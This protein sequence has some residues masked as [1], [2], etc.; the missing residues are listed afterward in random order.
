[1]VPVGAWKKKPRPQGLL[2]FQY[3]G[4]MREDPFSKSPLAVNYRNGSEPFKIF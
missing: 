3:G 2:V 4:D 1:M